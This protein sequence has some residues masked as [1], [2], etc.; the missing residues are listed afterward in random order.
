MEQRTRKPRT[1][2]V[3]KKKQQEKN[4]SIVVQELRV[5]SADRS[6][7]DIQTFK[8]SLIGAESVTNPNRTRLIDL[9]K[10][11]ILDGHLFGIIEKRIAKVV[12]KEIHFN[13]S[14]GKRVEAMDDLIDSE[15]FRDSMSKMLESIFWG[16]SGLEFLPGAEYDWVEIPRKHIKPELG[17]ISYMQNGREGIPYK[18]AG[19]MLIIGKPGDLGLLLQC[20]PYAIWKRGAMADT[21]QYI[22]IFGQPVRVVKYDAYD[23]KTQGELK[24]VLDE[25][26]SSLALMIP[27]QADFEMMDGK[28]ANATGELQETF[29]LACN[30]EMS[31]VISGSSEATTSSKGSSGFA[32]SKTHQEESEE[33]TKSDMKLLVSLLND[34]KFLRILQSY[35]YPVEGGKFGY[36]KETNLEDLLIRKEIDE[37]VSTQ[38]PVGDTYWYDTYG[39]PMPENYKELK[40]K[41]EA[42]K[43][44]AEDVEFEEVDKGKQ[45]DKNPTDTSKK[46][47][48]KTK[49][50]LNKLEK[51][52][53]GLADFFDLAR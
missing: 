51:L 29:R 42:S 28:T 52:R 33:I 38:V 36:E 14:Q 49:P 50:K 40:T 11:I 18:D 53:A 5:Q 32:Q 2:G 15:K 23:T 24:K 8:M 48:Q 39:I 43:E 19:N 44:L 47:P 45:G 16:L 35:G 41:M 21:S 20:S 34:K 4:P 37:F 22:E 7:K 13:D 30:Q 46:K 25:S 1:R 17:I 9:Y 31:I 6:R 26:G 12:N 3:R 10:D 27:K